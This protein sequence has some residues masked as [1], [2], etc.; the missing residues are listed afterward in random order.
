MIPVNDPSRQNQALRSELAAAVDV[1]LDHGK[2]IGGPEVG[3]F[4]EAFR[5]WTGAAD[6]VGVA[7][8]TDALRLMLQAGGV[9]PGDEVLVPDF[10]MIATPEAVLQLG[11]TPVLVEVLPGTY[12]IDPDAAAEAVTDRTRAALV[13]SLF[14]NPC[15]VPALPDT[16]TVYEDACQAHGASI[17][18]AMVGTLGAAGGFSFFP[19]KNLGGIGD[20]GMVVTMDPDLGERIRKLRNHGRT[21]QYEH[22]RWGWNSRLDTIQ[23]AALLVKLRH[24]DAGTA[25]RQAIAALYRDR[26]AELDLEL[27]VIVDGGISVS[28]LFVVACDD[29]DRLR[30]RLA[31]KGVGSAVHYE[32]PL[33]RQP[34]LAGRAVGPPRPETTARIC[35]RVLSLPCF[36]E[37]T[38]AEVDQVAEAVVDAL[39]SP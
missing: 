37:L 15:P 24:L 14:G 19:A 29:R 10:T 3:E 13:V 31:A 34:A 17:D 28:N 26:F 23:A 11:A 16:V 30:D 33:H 2:F 20:G 36:P 38:D 8:G 25:R 35:S 4:E 9:G 12:G 22:D 18:G 6:A 1:V 7:N 5:A 21:A 39:S 32:L 27:P